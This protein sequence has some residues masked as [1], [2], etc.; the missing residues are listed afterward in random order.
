MHITPPSIRSFHE[1]T[2]AEDALGAR[3][4]LVAI[5]ERYASAVAQLNVTL[6]VT[7]ASALVLI[8]DQPAALPVLLDG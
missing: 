3:E 2:L 7:L 1:I 6:V 4:P 5:L 8:A